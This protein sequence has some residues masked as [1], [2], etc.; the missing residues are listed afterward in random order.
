MIAVNSQTGF[1]EEVQVFFRTA[2][3]LGRFRR[4]NDRSQFEQTLM[5]LGMEPAEAQ[6]YWDLV[7]VP[8]NES[9][10]WEP[11]EYLSIQT[12]KSTSMLADRLGITLKNGHGE[13]PRNWLLFR[14]FSLCFPNVL[15]AQYTGAQHY[16]AK[17]ARTAQDH[18]MISFSS[19]PIDSFGMHA[20]EGDPM[21]VYRVVQGR[22]PARFEAHVIRSATS[23]RRVFGDDLGIRFAKVLT[24]LQMLIPSEV[25]ARK[26][27]KVMDVCRSGQELIFAGAFCPD[28]GYVETGNPL[29][30]YK[31]T[32][33]TLGEG[34]GL[35]AR[36]F[37]R[38][39]PEL[40]LF[41]A[42][43]NIP[44]RFVIGIG[45]FEADSQAVLERVGVGRHEF[46]RRCQCSL[47]AFKLLMPPEVLIELEL[48]GA[49]RG[50]GVFR[51]YALESTK[52]MLAG[53]FGLMRT[54][55][56]DLAEVIARIPAQYRTFYERWYQK[57]MDDASLRKLVFE[58]GGEYASVARIYQQ[59]FG[60]NVIFLAGDRP[61]M[62]RFNAFWAPCP[63]LCAKRAY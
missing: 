49:A 22:E 48:F 13:P 27:L 32:F 45:D 41:F 8:G 44:H 54:L 29:V 43:L 14:V 33:D 24:D 10:C 28:Y 55:H 21:S 5:A 52:R 9:S 53:D 40:S 58:Q 62:N 39:I 17:D 20:R 61:E 26:L 16:P 37:A 60:D 30:P 36:Q 12:V 47:D 57:E 51:Q 15:V 11:M 18:R 19:L 38:I 50:K 23:L 63:V 6:R 4:A 34:V 2:Q 25:M 7:S 56:P 1:Q 35:V 31:Y 59:D 46:I 3:N 42:E